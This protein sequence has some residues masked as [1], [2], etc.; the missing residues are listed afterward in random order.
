MQTG[1]KFLTDE[2]VVDGLRRQDNRIIEAVFKIYRP[3]IVKHILDLGG[4][5]EEAKDIFQDAMLAL[6]LRTK[7]EG[8]RL[9]SKFYT[10]LF[11]ICHNLW[12]KKF[13]DKKKF[14]EMSIEDL[15]VSN[16]KTIQDTIE[17]WE[18]YQLFTGH[19]RNLGEE[20]QKLIA[21]LFL[22]GKKPAD[23][24]VLMQFSSLSYL[25]KRKS[26]CKGELIALVRKDSR[27]AELASD[28]IKTVDRNN[29]DGPENI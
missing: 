18:R 24:V 23:V 11:S 3:V 10:F 26:I 17:G 4:S 2:M 21:Y 28:N 25:Y 20:C 29:S 27:F 5:E 16:D 19:F 15:E 1:A 9:T 8:F 12:L 13:R 14:T 22:E 6:F 7:D